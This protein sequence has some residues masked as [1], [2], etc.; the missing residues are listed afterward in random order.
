[1]IGYKLNAEAGLQWEKPVAA[2]LMI[3][4]LLTLPGGCAKQKIE[5]PAAIPNLDLSW[6]EVM[7]RLQSQYSQ[8]RGVPYRHGGQSRK[9]IDCSAFVQL[10]FKQQFGLNLPRTT[11]KLSA[12]GR[13]I[14]NTGL[15]PGDLI[16]FKTGWR[17]RHVGI[18]LEKYRFL[19]ASTTEGVTI[20][21][22]TEPYWY[23]RYWQARRVFN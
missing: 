22:M 23:G 9:G 12:H 14:I 17:D 11:Q 8:W 10:T 20:S 13:Q 16:M 5:P 21:K 7:N 4:F 18:Y 6:A 3:F 15:R 2:W 1:M 19:H